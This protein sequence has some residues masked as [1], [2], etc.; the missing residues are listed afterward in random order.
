MRY[1][2]YL[3]Q[4]A[5]FIACTCISA[6]STLVVGTIETG[7]SEKNENGRLG[8]NGQ[9]SHWVAPARLSSNFLENLLDL[10]NTYI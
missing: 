9:K 3:G 1:H 5:F 8:K 4:N 10:C 6:T 7:V 2:L